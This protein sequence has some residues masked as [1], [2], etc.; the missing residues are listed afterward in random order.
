MR[1]SNED[2][3]SEQVVGAPS[4]KGM[5]LT[6]PGELRSF[7]AYPRC[8][9]DKRRTVAYFGSV[10]ERGSPESG[11]AA[12]GR[13]EVA[14]R[15]GKRRLLI[16]G[17]PGYEFRLWARL[18][19]PPSEQLGQAGL[20]NAVLAGQGRLAAQRSLRSIRGSCCPAE[21]PTEVATE[22]DGR[23]GMACGRTR[24]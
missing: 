7:A 11:E 5:K 19:R 13:I 22:N 8:S 23:S 18:G 20:A 14:R 12:A 9:P 17:Q 2:R 21:W 3:M 6:K 24:G 4:N 15:P 16:Q 10:D 1:F